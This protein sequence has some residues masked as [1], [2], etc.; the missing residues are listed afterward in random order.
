MTFDIECVRTL[1]LLISEQVIKLQVSPTKPLYDA[2]RVTGEVSAKDAGPKD[3]GAVCWI[4]VGF[5]RCHLKKSCAKRIPMG[6]E[7]AQ[8]MIFPHWRRLHLMSLSIRLGLSSVLRQVGNDPPFCTFDNEEV[9]GRFA[10]VHLTLSSSDTK[11][12]GWLYLTTR[13]DWTPPQRRSSCRF[14]VCRRMVWL[15]EERGDVGYSVGYPAVVVHA[16]SKD[17]N[18]CD[19]ERCLYLQLDPPEEMESLDLECSVILSPED[20]GT[21]MRVRVRIHI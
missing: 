16:I 12:S 6:S 4:S 9:R 10:A 13:S 17:P 7:A 20:V 5:D 11:G 19:G 3:D 14:V 21:G 2:E 18:V 15:S 8:E 1:A